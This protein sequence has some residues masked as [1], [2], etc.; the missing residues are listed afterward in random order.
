M[1]ILQPFDQSGILRDVHGVAR[2]QGLATSLAEML[3][4]AAEA[5]PNQEALVEVDGDATATRYV[6]QPF[7]KEPDF[8]VSSINY[9]LADL[10][11][12]ATAP[13]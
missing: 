5:S 1:P 7:Q 10:M 4:N 6:R 2:Y 3:L 11:A 13:D 9:K 12:R 8:G